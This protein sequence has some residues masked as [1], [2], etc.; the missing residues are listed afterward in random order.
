MVT[1]RVPAGDDASRFGVVQTDTDNR[2]TDFAYKPDEPR[3]DQITAEVFVYDAARLLG[4]L[5]EIVKEGGELKDYGDELLPRLVKGGRAWAFPLDGY[6]RDVGTVESYCQAHADLLASDDKLGLDHPDW[7]IL[8]YGPQHLPARFL[9]RSKVAN[10]LVSP[11][12]TVGGEVT[13]SVLSPGV[14]VEPG[15]TVVRSILLHDAR[16]CAGARVDG[17]VVDENAEVGSRAVVGGG[18]G[19]PA[20]VGKG[21]RIP[22]GGRVAPGEELPPA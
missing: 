13:H 14:V 21:A 5:D 10:S 12:C 8:T 16:V 4:T 15:A 7:P 19:K 6:W 22:A 17:T 20:V 1:T 18:E 3:G 2:V 11:G 9:H